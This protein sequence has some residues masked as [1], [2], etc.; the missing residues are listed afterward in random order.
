MSKI[1]GWL[2]TLV[3]AASVAVSNAAPDF[4]K[5]A[6]EVGTRVIYENVSG[7]EVDQ[8][9]IPEQ[10]KPEPRKTPDHECQFEVEPSVI[11]G[12]DSLIFQLKSK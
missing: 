8:A 1:R 6:I 4:V 9:D 12:R 11:D 2:G 10:T 7:T 3:I 5:P